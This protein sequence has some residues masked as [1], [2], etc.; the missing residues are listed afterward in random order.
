MNSKVERYSP[1]QPGE[2]VKM[3]DLST[4]GIYGWKSGPK[5]HAN[6]YSDGI[7]IDIGDIGL[8]IAALNCTSDEDFYYSSTWA[9]IFIPN[10]GISWFPTH[11]LLTIDSCSCTTYWKEKFRELQ[12]VA[13]LE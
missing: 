12:N 6:H 1:K 9:C 10:K 11:C 7:R 3:M 2:L 4:D 8:V 13:N 5:R